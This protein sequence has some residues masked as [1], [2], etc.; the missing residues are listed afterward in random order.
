MRAAAPP[1]ETVQ[2]ALLTLDRFR[3]G[4]RVTR[5]V[6][7]FGQAGDRRE[8]VVE[9]DVAV[10]SRVGRLLVDHFDERTAAELVRL[11]TAGRSHRTEPAARRVAIIGDIVVLGNATVKAR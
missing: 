4:Q 5:A 10:V 1:R 11:A 9:R 6:G 3:D 2:V 8:L 7:D